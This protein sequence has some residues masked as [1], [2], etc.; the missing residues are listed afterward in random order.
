MIR[1]QS[2]PVL[3]DMR[4]IEGNFDQILKSNPNEK[5]SRDLVFFSLLDRVLVPNAMNRLRTIYPNALGIF[6][7]RRNENG[8]LSVQMCIRD[9]P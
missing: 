9:R 2:L 8:D 5:E 1:R 7:G 3:R 6:M 4:M